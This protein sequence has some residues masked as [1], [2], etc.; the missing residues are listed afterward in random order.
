MQLS[1]VERTART[2]FHPRGK[3]SS[4]SSSLQPVQITSNRPPASESNTGLAGRMKHDTATETAACSRSMAWNDSPQEL[5]LGSI[6]PLFDESI[7]RYQLLASVQ[8][9][10]KRSLAYAHLRYCNL[11]ARLCGVNRFEKTGTCLIHRSS[12]RRRGSVFFSECM[13][14]EM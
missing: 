14:F 6:P 1:S 12:L 5:N 13:Q 11:C 7:P 2:P 8:E 3:L 4:S 10:K 9:A